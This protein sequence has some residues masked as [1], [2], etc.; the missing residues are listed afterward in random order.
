MPGGRTSLAILF[1]ARGSRAQL[2]RAA[3]QAP[4][5][6]VVSSGRKRCLSCCAKQA[7]TYPTGGAMHTR[8]VLPWMCLQYLGGAL[9]F[10]RA[11]C[12]RRGLS[13]KAHRGLSAKAHMGA[14]LVGSFLSY[15][16][17][18]GRLYTRGI[19]CSPV[20]SSS[21]RSITTA[22]ALFGKQSAIAARR[23]L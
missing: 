13:A 22:H 15:L 8:T 1:C 3:N 12:F 16:G 14:L 17:Q 19:V 21:I 10:R 20:W 9:S 5:E 7:H 2:P 6:C 23:R 18:A 11:R 4:M